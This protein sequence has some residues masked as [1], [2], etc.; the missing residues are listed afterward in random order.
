MTNLFWNHIFKYHI[1]INA[2]L[3]ARTM[4]RALW[5][6]CATINYIEIFS[7]AP[8]QPNERDYNT[9]YVNSRPQFW[10]KQKYLEKMQWSCAKPSIKIFVIM[11]NT[12]V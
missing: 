12:S 4:M 8:F 1:E 3:K 5:G 7:W 11:E 2:N 10:K 6:G 9:I